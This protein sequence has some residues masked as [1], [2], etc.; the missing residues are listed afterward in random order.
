MFDFTIVVLKGAY[1]TSV[2]ASVD[3]LRAASALA[4]RL[5][6]SPPR[7]RVCSLAGGNVQ[8]QG[9]LTVETSKLKLRSKLD[10]STWV[11]PGLGLDNVEHVEIRLLEND[12]L[13]LAS[14]L[15][16]HVALG[17][18]VAASCSAVFILH[19][20]GLLEGKR[21]TTSW[22][23]APALK[24][25]APDCKLNA[26]RMVCADGQLV[27]AGAAFAH[28]DL[29]LHLLATAYGHTLANTVSRVLLIDGRQAQSPF[30]VPEVMANGDE[31]VSRVAARIDFLLPN[32]PSV[33]DLATHFCMSKR[34]LA[35][36]L[37]KATGQGPLALLQN[38]RF[39]RARTLLESSRMTI[40]QVAEAVGYKD[41]TALRSMMKKRAGVNPS[42]YR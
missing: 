20:A 24:R 31:L 25:L 22:W 29:M 28:A 7:W 34:T 41:S 37:E 5:N 1:P 21:A 36:H 27:T 32:A 2:A 33:G 14:A 10:A 40:D 38:V 9:G 16:H 19:V 11:I 6:L 30:I 39:R 18:E 26:D 13:K 4:P 42:R 23:L 15:K 12:V 8:L 3:L 17:H 35:R